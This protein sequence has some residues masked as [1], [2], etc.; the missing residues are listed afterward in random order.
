[1]LQ[2]SFDALAE[3]QAVYAV[4]H[5]RGDDLA[6]E[7]LE[8]RRTIARLQMG[9]GQERQAAAALPGLHRDA[10]AVLGPDDPLTAEIHDLLTRLHLPGDLLG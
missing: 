2:G 10:V 5:R 4:H 9:V 6:E 3:Y 1:M 7:V 8:L